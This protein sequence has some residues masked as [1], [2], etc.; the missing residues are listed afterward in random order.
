M[1]EI[2]IALQPKQITF[3]ESVE[4]YPVTFFGGA[5][6]GGKSHAL[7]NILII[8]LSKIPKTR[9]LLIRKTFDELISNHV[10]E[11]QRENP[12]IMKYYNKGERALVLPNGSMLKFRHLQHPNDVFNYQGQQFDYIAIDE[13]TQHEKKTFTT[14]RS[15]NRTTNPLV[16]PRFILT[17]NP[18]G[19]GHGWVRK[20]FI[21]KE[22]EYNERPED[23]NFV[24]A[25]VYDN[26]E[27][28]NNDPEYVARLEALPKELR[29]AYLNGNWDMFEGQFFGEWNREIHVVEPHPLMP[30]FKRFISIDYGFN[31]PSSVHWYAVNYLG[32]VIV[33]RELYE[34]G[35]TFEQLGFK[36]ARMTPGED[37][38]HNGLVFNERK[39]ISYITY[40]PSIQSRKGETGTSGEELLRKGLKEGQLECGMI[41]AN[42]NRKYGWG[43]MREFLKLKPDAYGKASA[44]IEWFSTCANAIRT[45]PE[46]IYSATILEDLDTDGEDHVADETRYGLVSM[47]IKPTE[48]DRKLIQPKSL[49]EKAF[50]NKLKAIKRKHNLGNNYYRI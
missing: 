21:N 18:G 12:E 13:A 28:M 32:K 11:L 41:P 10:E 7:R 5:K 6:G 34:T 42:N 19:I 38:M 48:V 2:H 1:E 43:V 49:A 33:Y 36:I 31:A 22:Y 30:N 50:Y 25:R 8:L 4:K 39:N 20:L 35:L 27:I 47:K 46:Q 26:L 14:L 9:A 24:P 16:K 3:K 45:I 29:E 40:D 37:E 23:Y 44:G 15:S 17:G